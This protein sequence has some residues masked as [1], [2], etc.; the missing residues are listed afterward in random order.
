MV[1]YPR[2][3]YT[4][5][6][7]G[8]SAGQQKSTKDMGFTIYCKRKDISRWTLEYGNLEWCGYV[9]FNSDI[10]PSLPEIKNAFKTKYGWDYSHLTK[11]DFEERFD[12]DPRVNVAFLFEIFDRYDR[13]K[14]QEFDFDWEKRAL[15]S[16]L[17]ENAYLALLSGGNS[18]IHS[19]VRGRVYDQY[20]IRNCKMQKFPAV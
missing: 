6:R 20:A 19:Y 9:Q 14:D 2:F 18:A 11:D 4:P 1:R 5:V 10:K 17:K 13:E 12:A 7:P 16:T 15:T 8:V 3:F